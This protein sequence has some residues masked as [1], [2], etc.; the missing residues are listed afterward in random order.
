MR[1][2]T[3]GKYKLLDRIS[4]GGM[5]EVFLGRSVEIPGDPPLA[6]KRILPSMGRIGEFVAMFIDEA[7]IALQLDH[8]NVLRIHELGKHA[9]NTT[10]RWSTS[11]AAICGSRWSG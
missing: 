2:L 11:R 9:D 4:V 7:R 1:P 3:F 5:A 8:P 6:I 10:S